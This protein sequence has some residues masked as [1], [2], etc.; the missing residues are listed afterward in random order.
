MTIREVRMWHWQRAQSAKQKAES[1][2][3]KQDHHSKSLARQH[4]G[5]HDFHVKCVHALNPLFHSTVEQDW[6]RVEEYARNRKPS[7]D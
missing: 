6:Q 5:R 1:Y 4:A 2:K 7:A 3:D